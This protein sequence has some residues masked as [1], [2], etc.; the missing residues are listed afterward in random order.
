MS[1]LSSTSTFLV[2]VLPLP[3]HVEAGDTGASRMEFPVFP[4]HHDNNNDDWD[5]SEDHGN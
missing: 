1:F 3:I 5:E 2:S 4:Q